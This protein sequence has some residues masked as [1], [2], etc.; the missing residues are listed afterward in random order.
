MT[1]T[2]KV[3]AQL[4]PS[5]STLTPLYTVPPSTSTVV[6]S[7]TICNQNSTVVNIRVSVAVAGAGDDPK[8]YVYYKLPMG[9][10]DTFIAT[11]GLSLATTDVIRCYSDTTNV[12]FSAFGVELT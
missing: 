6:S 1:Q 12:S 5:A 8:Q 7:L 4:S 2:M 11:V 3:L 10:F 9:A